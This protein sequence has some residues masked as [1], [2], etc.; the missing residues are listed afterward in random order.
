MARD[1]WQQVLRGQAYTNTPI[2]STPATSSR[3]RPGRGDIVE[4]ALGPRT[5]NGKRQPAYVTSRADSLESDRHPEEAGCCPD[6]STQAAR[7][8]FGP[9]RNA[10]NR[11]RPG[12]M[13]ALRALSRTSGP[14]AAAPQQHPAFL[15]AGR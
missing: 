13:L 1:F 15:S 11:D 9:A 4:T 10:R 8:Q 3:I 7:C 5:P 12:E 2:L 6:W 14:A